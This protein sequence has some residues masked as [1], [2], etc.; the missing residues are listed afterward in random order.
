MRSSRSPSAGR[1]SIC[2]AFIHGT[3][4]GIEYAG[5]TGFRDDARTVPLARFGL[6]VGERF[7]YEYDFS[8]SWVHDLRVEAMV[9][10]EAGRA[11]PRCTGGR[12]AGPPEGCDGPWAFMDASGRRLPALVRTAQIVGALLDDPD[13][14]LSGYPDELAE[15]AELRP[16][17]TPER[18]FDRRAVN[19]RLAQL[20]PRRGP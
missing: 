4:Y 8:A 13:G 5:G 12:R 17:L 11:Y 9:A 1:T 14:R 15:L 6:R 20:A 16:W 18:R 2:T 7:V 19:R 3:G 10:V